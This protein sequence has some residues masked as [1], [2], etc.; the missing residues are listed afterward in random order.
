M[1]GSVR[2]AGLVEP[3]A[4]GA[5]HAVHHAAGR[6]HVGAGPGM[7]DALCRQE[8]QRRVVVDVEP[9]GLSR[10]ARRNGRDRCTRRNTRR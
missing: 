1:I 10:S 6:D 5:D 2:E 9:A 3:G 4:D 7:A 8:R